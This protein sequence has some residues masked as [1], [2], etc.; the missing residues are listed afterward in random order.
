MF[1]K[2]SKEDTLTALLQNAKIIK[3]CS[4]KEEDFINLKDVE[5]FAE[6]SGQLYF[7]KERQELIKIKGEQYYR[8]KII[9]QAPVESKELNEALIE[10]NKK[11]DQ[12][13]NYLGAL[14]NLAKNNK[15]DIDILESKLDNILDELKEIKSYIN[16]PAEKKEDLPI[17]QKQ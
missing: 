4:I 15:Q 2:K 7:F 11:M 9:T 6:I 10:T 12:L 5:A 16:K 3:E 17:L 13:V 1:G 14:G 8:L